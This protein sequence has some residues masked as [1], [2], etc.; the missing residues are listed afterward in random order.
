LGDG[1][2]AEGSGLGGSKTERGG[3]QGEGLAQVAGVE[4]A[5]TVGTRPS[6]F[7]STSSVGAGPSAYG[8]SRTVRPEIPQRR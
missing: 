2:V 7:S 6:S 3:G 4:Q 8:G 1:G 5:D